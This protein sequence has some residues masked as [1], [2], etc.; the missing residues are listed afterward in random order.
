MAYVMVLLEIIP[1]ANRS[2]I[3]I[4][5]TSSPARSPNDSVNYS[6]LLPGIKVKGVP[7]VSTKISQLVGARSKHHLS[8][9]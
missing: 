5:T 9:L 3:V 1:K 7:A 6:C 2:Y 8:C 4:E